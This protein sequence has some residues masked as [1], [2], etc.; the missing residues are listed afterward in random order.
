MERQRAGEFV[1]DEP[2]RPIFACMHRKLTGGVKS[3]YRATTRL[4]AAE[5]AGLVSAPVG[6]ASIVESEIK[7][8]VFL[9]DLPPSALL[10]IQTMHHRY[11]AVLPG[12]GWNS[13]QSGVGWHAAGEH[14][15]RWHQWHRSGRLLHHQI[16]TDF[17]RERRSC[18]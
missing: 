17:L 9:R 18:D 10:H 11:T 15:V 2:I 16:K 13:L 14:L 8:G 3:E 1:A 5:A 12:E 4:G 6:R 7:G